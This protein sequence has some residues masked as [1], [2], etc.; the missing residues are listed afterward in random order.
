MSHEAFVSVV[1]E[2]AALTPHSHLGTLLRCHPGWAQNGGHILDNFIVTWAEWQEKALSL[3]SAG[4]LR[5]QILILCIC[6]LPASD[7]A[8]L[9]LDLHAQ[10]HVRDHHPS[11]GSK[12]SVCF[13]HVLRNFQRGWKQKLNQDWDAG[14]DRHRYTEAKPWGKGGS[15]Q[16]GRQ[17]VK[18]CNHTANG[19]RC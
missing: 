1:R 13:L 12:Q 10:K 19:E 16:R 2:D 3:K 6:A 7:K 9:E 4:V 18:L 17:E 14:K 15:K 5:S 8:L 11:L